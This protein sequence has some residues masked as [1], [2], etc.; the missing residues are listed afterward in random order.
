MRRAPRLGRRA[1]RALL[2]LAL[3]AVGGLAA[4]L[5][6]LAADDGASTGP[7]GGQPMPALYP[8]RDLGP[9]TSLVRPAE[10]RADRAAQT[11]LAGH[12]VR[13]DAAFANYAIATVGRP[14]GASVQRKELAELHAIGAH[15]TAAGVTAAGWLELHGKKDVWKLYLKQYRQSV[16]SATGKAAKARFKAAYA[17]AKTI[18]AT[19]KAHFARVTPYQV[20]PTL[21]AVNQS[22]FTAK[23]YSYP[24]KHAVIGYAESTLL[25]HLEPH[26]APEFDWMAGELAYSRLY[27]GGHY[28]SDISAG[29]YLGRLIADYEL[30][31]R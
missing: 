28:P 21:R 23:K 1:L 16:P 27:A 8:D 3:L 5:N 10:A 26:R 24:S 18:A 31:A 22:K 11:W 29:I 17:L 12:P 4:A 30:G 19:A 6:V 20:D 9:A 7:Y 13:D 15:R 2:V 14:P 25:A